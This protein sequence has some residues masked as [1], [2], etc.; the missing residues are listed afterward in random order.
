ML[1]TQERALRSACPPGVAPRQEVEDLPRRHARAVTAS[2]PVPVLVVT[3]TAIGTTRRC[4]RSKRIWTSRW[5]RAHLPSTTMTHSSCSTTS[6]SNSSNSDTALLPPHTQQQHRHRHSHLP[7][8]STSPQRRTS[9]PPHKHLPP[10]QCLPTQVRVKG[11]IGSLL[12]SASPHTL[13][14]GTDGH[15]DSLRLLRVPCSNRKRMAFQER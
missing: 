6:N 5:R 3:I 9:P 8:H 11:R 12:Q 4:K 10:H 14:L 2:Q 13:P 7:I 15:I 1:C